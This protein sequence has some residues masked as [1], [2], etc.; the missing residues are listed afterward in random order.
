MGMDRTL[1]A[2]LTIAEERNL[3]AAADRM[4]L[5]QPSLTK[6]LARLE[7][8]LGVRLFDRLPRGMALTPYGESLYK[9]AR[10]IELEYR[11]AR[12]ELDALKNGFRHVL[13]I[14]AGPLYHL[15]H[16]PKVLEVILREFPKTRLE[17]VADVNAKT[18]PLLVNGTLD[19][20][21]GA[22]DIPEVPPGVETEK[23]T[24]S[25]YG[26]IVRSSH[27]LMRKKALTARDLTGWTWIVYQQDEVVVERLERY[28]R[29][30]GFEPPS[31]AVQTSSFAA[32]LRL[33]SHGDYI[34]AAPTQ[35]APAIAEAGLHILRT[36]E[37]MWRFPSGVWY[38]SSS[39]G[40]PIIQRF[41]AIT[42]DVVS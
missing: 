11:F 42:K 7:R 10:A 1:K 18:V 29:Q 36:K 21:L 25:D 3:T 20:V 14:G 30:H 22:I 31:I 5:A 13:R 35:L 34:M 27:P 17:L 16:A 23:L 39:L 38:R 4:A 9:R 6:M 28:F 40:Y 37:T 41:I 26:V 2:F 33:V 12:E 15:V 8:D 24:E 32:G 19:I